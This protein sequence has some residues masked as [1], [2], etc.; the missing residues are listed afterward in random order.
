MSKTKWKKFYN[1]DELKQ[2]QYT[3]NGTSVTV[4]SATLMLPKLI[5]KEVVSK[6]IGEFPSV[7][8]GE[9]EAD[10]EKETSKVIDDKILKSLN[11]AVTK[12]FAYGEG[13]LIPSLNL[14]GQ[15]VTDVVVEDGN[16]FNIN[17][18]ET[19]G[20]LER[21]QYSKR[22]NRVI[23]NEIVTKTIIYDHY[24][25]KDV[26]RFKKYYEEDD[27]K[28]YLDGND[29]TKS[30]SDTRMLPSRQCLYLNA[31]DDPTPVYANAKRLIEDA[32]KVYHEMMNVMELQRPVVGIPSDLVGNEARESNKDMALM[33]EVH[34]IF[35]RVF[36]VEG[37][38]WE[39]FGGEYD[40]EP[41]LKLLNFLLH[42]I[43]Q[44][45]GLGHRYLTYDRESGTVRTAT[46]VLSTQSDLYINQAMLN[47]TVEGIIN[48]IVI[49]YFYLTSMT[50]EFLSDEDIKIEFGDSVYNSE[51]EKRDQLKFDMSQGFITKK[52]YLG[53][54]YPHAN[55]A[56]I[57][58][59]EDEA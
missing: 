13:F 46:E 8:I 24:M 42:S 47:Q 14:K 29:G 6:Q 34:R 56:D 10:Q 59:N 54:I 58:S 38:K 22:E 32:N 50:S 41:Y 48:E 2:T 20:S 28:I 44:Q 11:K 37:D 23:G 17:Y 43:S 5:V 7:K 40:P 1:Q 53:E 30:I 4:K 52:F 3:G 55:T 33:S 21:L 57:L 9:S 19:D 16:A 36:G 25:E 35:A 49:A 26:Y 45:S 12:I 51:Q 39:Y 15:V 18:A 27:K 31:D